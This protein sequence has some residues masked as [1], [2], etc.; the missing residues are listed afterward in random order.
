MH[1]DLCIARRSASG[2]RSSRCQSRLLAISRGFTL[3]EVVITLGLVA[4]LSN[5]GLYSF[6]QFIGNSRA[7]TTIL[8]LRTALALARSEAITRNA[9]VVL[10]RRWEQQQQCAGSGAR[11]RPDWSRGWLLFVDTDRNKVLDSAA[12]DQILRIFPAIYPGLALHWNR[13]DYIA[14]QGSG[15][16]HSLNGTFCLIGVGDKAA[17][18]R[19]LKIPYTGRV[20]ITSDECSYPIP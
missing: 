4:V 17:F 11:G 3:T 2:Y 5:I 14:Y 8:N 18:R 15:A 12:G 20:R 16:L 10:C 7:D 6:E 19:E 9:S 13:G 1:K